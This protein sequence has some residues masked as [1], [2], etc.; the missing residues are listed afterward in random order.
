MKLRVFIIV[1]LWFTL[2]ASHYAGAKTRHDS[3]SESQPD[4]DLYDASW[5]LLPGLPGGS[6][7]RRP[8]RR[9][10][11]SQHRAAAHPTPLE[12]DPVFRRPSEH[13]RAEL[14]ALLKKI[15]AGKA[16]ATDLTPYWK[17]PEGPALLRTALFHRGR[18][19]RVAVLNTGRL[20]AAAHPRLTGFMISDTGS[21]H[22]TVATAAFRFALAAD[23]DIPALYAADALEHRLSSVRQQ[24]ILA[25]SNLLLSRGSSGPWEEVSEHISKRERVPALIALYCRIVG[26]LGLVMATGIVESL[27]RHRD[28][29]VRAEALVA[30]ARLRGKLSAKQL[31]WLSKSKHIVSYMRAWAAIGVSLTSRSE[32][33][34]SQ[35]R[36]QKS[37]LAIKDK[38][39]S[40]SEVWHVALRGKEL[41]AW[42]GGQTPNPTQPRE[43]K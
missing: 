39:A 14:G 40:G 41:R 36:W 10:D 29:M 26:Q 33:L 11:L 43:P 16:K 28:S 4:P 24:F 8:L 34:Q 20:L 30:I 12:Q 42:L 31:R 19:A 38:L 25:A 22:A 15:D 5:R 9:C 2:G 18:R 17:G 27:S 3:A 1:L 7:Q 21:K 32:R 37:R 6:M 23:C 13:L 35:D